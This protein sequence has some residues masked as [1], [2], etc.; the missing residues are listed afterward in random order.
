MGDD[1]GG[2]A[3]EERPHPAFFFES[4]AKATCRKTGPQLGH[5]ASGDVDTTARI[6]RYGRIASDGP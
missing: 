6:E 5:D 2:D 4:G 3:F 1:V